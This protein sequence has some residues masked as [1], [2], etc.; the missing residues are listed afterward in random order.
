MTQ[1]CTPE[2][3]AEAVAASMHMPN[4]EEGGMAAPKRHMH[5]AT[6]RCKRLCQVTQ[7]SAY[8]SMAVKHR[9]MSLV[10]A[11]GAAAPI[12]LNV[13]GAPRIL[14]ATKMHAA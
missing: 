11:S 7:V 13:R 5:A 8:L 6:K 10:L 12:S 14:Q 4:K 2:P 3:R 1:M 9:P